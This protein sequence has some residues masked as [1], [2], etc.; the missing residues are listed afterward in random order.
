MEIPNTAFIALGAIVAALLTGTFS[1]VSL[2][3][4]KEGKISEFRQAWID[5]I[6]DDLAI[7]LSCIENISGDWQVIRL[8]EEKKEKPFQG[9]DWLNKFHAFVRDDAVRFYEAHQR[10][11]M[12]LNEDEHSELIDELRQAREYISDKDLLYD[13][14]ALR[15]KTDKILQQAQA[16]LKNE[17]EVV[18]AGEKAYRRAKNTSIVFVF[19]LLCGL[20]AASYLIFSSNETSNKSIQPTAEASVD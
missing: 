14:N 2:I 12:R 4:Q 3:N 10:I 19:F 9:S 16:I 20:G 11:L 6:R 5:S 1:F 8:E 17:W 15:K 18:K 13:K 7:L